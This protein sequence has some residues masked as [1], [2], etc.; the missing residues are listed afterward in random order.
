MSWGIW[1]IIIFLALLSTLS[2]TVAMGALRLANQAWQVGIKQRSSLSYDS[3]PEDQGGDIWVIYNPSKVEDLAEFKETIIRQALASGYATPTFN[4]TKIDDPGRNI[5]EMALSQ[6][7]KLVI[8]AGGDGTVRSVASALAHSHVPLGIIPLGTGNL[9]ARNLNIPLTSLSRATEIALTG[10][11]TPIDLGI[12]RTGMVQDEE[13]LVM[14][15]IGFDGE[16]MR[17]TSAFM[18][19][20]L[21]W[22]AYFVAGISSIFR[23]AFKVEVALGRDQHKRK[24]KVRS[25]IFASCGELLGGLTL[26]PDANPGDGWLDILYLKVRGGL[27]GWISVAKRVIFSGLGWQNTPTLQNS[28][29]QSERARTVEL[30]SL[31][32]PQ[33]VQVDGD[34]IGRFDHLEIRVEQHALLLRSP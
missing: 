13:F 17:R 20:S 27:L 26:L 32:G 30:D 33:E 19:D 21:G 10:K 5:T 9:L 7:A 23:P 28:Q 12:L 6:G 25:V 14:A 8:A 15:G 2:L 34:P 11:N 3:S 22:G 16:I 4:S 1:V 31:D 18:K 29:M 24:L